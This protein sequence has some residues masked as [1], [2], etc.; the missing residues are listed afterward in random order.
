MTN[1]EAARIA[2]ECIQTRMKFYAVN[3]NI[4]RMDPNA[5]ESC[6]YALKEYTRLAKALKFYNAVL[7]QGE[8]EL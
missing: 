5:P 3:A 1:K 2:V 7:V 6:R 8:M 4:A